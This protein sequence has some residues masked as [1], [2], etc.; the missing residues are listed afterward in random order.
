M[1]TRL[2]KLDRLYFGPRVGKGSAVNM[3][4]CLL[5]GFTPFAFAF[6]Y[7]NVPNPEQ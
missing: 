3:V 4:W 6:L 2:R 7:W 5:T 1:I